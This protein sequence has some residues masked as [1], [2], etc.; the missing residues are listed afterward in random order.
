MPKIGAVVIT[1]NEGARLRS[2]VE[3]LCATL[4]GDADLIVVD[5][6]STDDSTK[7]L[8]ENR[9]I[10][11]LCT[12]NVG[13]A[14]TRN[15]AVQ[16]TSAE[17]IVFLD[18]HVNLPA[19]WWEPMLELLDQTGAGAVAPAVSDIE[20]PDRKAFGVGFKGP[21]LSVE[22]L[23]QNGGEPYRVPLLPWCCTAVRRDI[24]QTIGGF[25]EDMI[26]WG[27][28]DVELSLRLWLLGYELWLAPQ[29]EVFHFFRH[30]RPYPVEW[31]WVIHNRLRTAFLHFSLERVTQV[32]KTLSTHQG[33]AAAVALAIARDIA[34]R[35]GELAAQ[36]V[37]DDQWF[38]ERFGPLG[39]NKP[40]DSESSLL[41]ESGSKK[42]GSE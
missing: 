11:L 27:G 40:T 33:F 29:V 16:H 23:R 8:S 39:G 15:L 14:R 18:A 12:G 10:Q 28:I 37:H 9:R 2:T 38:F 36:R 25:D 42:G 26:R 7:F 41:K 17:V 4:P 22:W 35:R 19:G 3:Q 5:D 31:S 21:D 1:L 32:V 6:G 13:T 20:E 30:A 24:F 34:A